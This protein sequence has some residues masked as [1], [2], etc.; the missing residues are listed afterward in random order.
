[1]A[2]REKRTVVVAVRTMLLHMG[3][4]HH[5]WHLALR[6]AVWVHK[7]LERASLPPRTS[8]YEL[9]FEKK[10]DLT[11]AR[12]WGCMVQFMVLDLTNN[13]VGS[14][15]LRVN[16]SGGVEGG[17]WAGVSADEGFSA[18]GSIAGVDSVARS[19]GRW[20]ICRSLLK[21][22]SASTHLPPNARHRSA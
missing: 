6:R 14:N 7:C 18:D 8:S 13:R 2:E 1:M 3:M 16:V 11:L 9:L 20:S 10:P 4:K 21:S 17:A 12:V 15:L 19:R 5:W 22:S